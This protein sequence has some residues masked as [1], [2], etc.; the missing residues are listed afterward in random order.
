MTKNHDNLPDIN[1]EDK[2]EAIE[3][4]EADSSL[5]KKVDQVLEQKEIS[6]RDFLRMIGLTSG[7]IAIGALGANTSLINDFADNDSGNLDTGSNVNYVTGDSTHAPADSGSTGGA[8]DTGSEYTLQEHEIEFVN[9]GSEPV[10][11]YFEVASSTIGSETV[12]N[13]TNN[14]TDT[15]NKCSESVDPSADNVIDLARSEYGVK[16]DGQ[17]DDT[18]AI[19]SVINDVNS[20]ETILLPSGTIRVMSDSGSA[21]SIDGSIPENVTLA[22]RGSETFIE[23]GDVD[24]SSISRCIGV[25]AS[26]AS[27]NGLE[28]RDMRISGNKTDNNNYSSFGLEIYPPGDGHDIYIHDIEVVDSSGKGIGIRGGNVRLE[29]ITATGNTRHG[30]GLRVAERSQG[31]W[32][33]KATDILAMNNGGLG[34]DHNGGSA[35]IERFWLEGNGQGGAKFPRRAKET[36]WINGTFADNETMGWR[37]N[38]DHTNQLHNPMRAHFDNCLTRDNAWSGWACGGNVVYDIG[39][40][41][42]IGDNKGDNQQAAIILHEE[43]RGSAEEIYVSNPTGYA[44]SATTYRDFTIGKLTKDPGT[45]VYK[46]RGSGLTIENQVN[47]DPPDLDLPE[48]NELGAWSNC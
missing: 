36:W 28:I 18:D 3:R 17:T 47:G 12:D 11:Y 14:N 27:I 31:E 41:V 24:D 38:G 35:R 44:L 46:P 1:I 26:G 25:D 30:I 43:A 39:T 4:I 37:F 32:A 2:K 6:R 22:G 5:R 29:R 16:A 19:Q 33:V 48:K 9:N 15:G 40:I 7:G 34:I 8:G 20:G 21:L 45:T 10:N 42:S 23:M 13:T